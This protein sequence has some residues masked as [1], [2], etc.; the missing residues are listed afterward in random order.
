LNVR[1]NYKLIGLR[2]QYRIIIL[3]RDPDI[4]VVGPII[5]RSKGCLILVIFDKED[6]LYIYLTV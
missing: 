5:N 1:S 2:Q 3:R 6:Y 4:S